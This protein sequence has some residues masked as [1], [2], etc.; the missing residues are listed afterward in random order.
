[1]PQQQ[2]RRHFLAAVTAVV[3]AALIPGRVLRAG[4]LRTVAQGP[5]PTPRAG[6]TGAK[7]LTKDQLADKPKL[8]SLF[9]SV[10]EIPEVVDGI[11]CNCG[12]THADGFYSL[13]SCYEGKDAMARECAICQGQGRLAVRLHKAGRSL[14]EIR[15]AVDAKFG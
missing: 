7:V 10:R 8:V 14:D 6:I 1:M 3:V 4:S 9:D 12:C 13:L 15:A 2:S 5:H 11:R